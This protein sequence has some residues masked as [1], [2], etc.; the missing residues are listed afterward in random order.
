MSCSPI[1]VVPGPTPKDRPIPR[2]PGSDTIS[3]LVVD[4]LPDKLMVFE[5]VL[6]QLGVNVVTARSGDEALRC[7]LE[8]DFAVILLDVNMPGMDG[9]ETA[10]FIRQRKKSAHTPIIFITAYADNVFNDAAST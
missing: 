3:V 10:R 1:I 5:T 2:M 7:V 6:E 4:D 8:H 9:Y